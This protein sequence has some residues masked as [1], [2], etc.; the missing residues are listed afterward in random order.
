MK[1]YGIRNNLRL[2]PPEDRFIL[3]TYHCPIT[4][5]WIWAG[6]VVR[7]GYA[8][9]EIKGRH[10]MAHKWAWEQ[11]NGPVPNGLV[12]DHFA[13]NNP[14]CVNPDHVRPVTQLENVLRGNTI[15]SNNVAKKDC[16]RCGGPYSY[17]GNGERCC[18]PC[19]NKLQRD[20]RH[21]NANCSK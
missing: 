11:K 15:T 10:V 13:C 6:G 2:L 19:R 8:T 18:K 3:Q 4:G 12:L 14:S 17:L 5:C 20:R 9:M 21:R 16:P 1:R 7:G